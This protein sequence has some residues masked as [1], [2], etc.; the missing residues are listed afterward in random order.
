MIIMTMMMMMMMMIT[1][2]VDP[3][4]SIGVDVGDHVVNICL[5]QVVT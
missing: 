4:T 1:L 2:E 3:A 5:G